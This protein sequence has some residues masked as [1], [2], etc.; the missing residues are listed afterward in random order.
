ML[1]CLLALCVEPLNSHFLL[2]LYFGR[3]TCGSQWKW[4][5]DLRDVLTSQER[6]IVQ[7]FIPGQGSKVSKKEKQFKNVKKMKKDLN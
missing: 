6:F 3:V 1:D 2:S 7:V 4:K 5:L